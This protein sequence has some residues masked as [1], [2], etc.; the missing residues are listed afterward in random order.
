MTSYAERGYGV[1]QVGFGEKPGI[2]VVDFQLAFTDPSF[3]TGGAAL[4]RRAVEN[5]ARL[6]QVARRAG[7]PVATCYMCYHSERD[8]P[9]WKVG[10]IAELVEGHPGTKLDPA[11]ADPSYD[12]VLRKGAPSIFFATPAAA[13][14]GKNRVDTMIVT[15]CI[16]SGCVRASIVDSFSLGFRTIVP[17]DCVGDHEDAPHRDNLRDVERRYADVSSADEVIRQIEAWRG[18]NQS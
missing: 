2:A 4:V 3:A 7:V 16:T 9:H 1:R 13:F 18:R 6:L 15:G 11:I 8:A 17:E 14:F 10:G 12:Y 5:T